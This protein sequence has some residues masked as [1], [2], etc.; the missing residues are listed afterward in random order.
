VTGGTPTATIADTIEYTATISWSTNPVTFTGGTIYTATITIIPKTGYILIGVPT[1]F[2]TVTGATSTNSINIGIVSAVFPATNKTNVSAPAAPTEVSKT[3]HTIILNA[4]ALNQFSKDG[5][6]WQDSN[7]FSGL[8]ASTQYTFL[9]RVK[10]T[11]TTNASIASTGIDITTND[12]L[13]ASFTANPN[14]DP[15][16]LTVNF[17]NNTSGNA[18]SYL[19]DFGNGATSSTA[20]PTYVYTNVGI[21]TV[22]LTATNSD[23]SNTITLNYLIHAGTFDDASFSYPSATYCQSGSP[24]TST[25]TGLPGGIFTATPAGMSVNPS[26]GT[27]NLNTSALGIYNLMYETN[28]TYPNTNSISMTITNVTPSSHFSYSTSTFAQSEVNPLPIFG[29]G[30]SAGMFTAPAG[31]VFT[32]PNTGGINLAASTPNTYIV[33]N[34]IPISGSC[35]EVIATTTVTITL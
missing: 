27:I 30:A 10:E 31:L 23:G 24:Q 2:F 21:Y 1:N 12:A 9:S 19:W 15:T 17:T 14:S 20:N 26:T 29:T 35:S 3:A 22:S 7:V 33:T 28:G 6:T 11:S 18:T 4:N 8:N 13:I 25:I 16:P 32:N 5:S 34:T